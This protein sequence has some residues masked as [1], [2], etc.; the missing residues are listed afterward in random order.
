MADP[1]EGRPLILDQTEARRAETIFF[2]HHPA[3]FLRVL[4]TAPQASQGMDPALWKG[5][6]LFC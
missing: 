5:M 2:W 3:L 1:G 4:M 6:Y